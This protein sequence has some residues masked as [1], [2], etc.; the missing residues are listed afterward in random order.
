LQNRWNDQE[1]KAAGSELALRCYTSQLLGRDPALVLHG[2]GNTSV[3]LAERNVLGEVED[4]L[5]VKGSGWDLA[6]IK[7]PGFAPVK[8]AHLTRLAQLPALSD[9]AMVNE[10]ATHVTRAS[11]PA[12]SVEAI[13]H[14]ILPY[15]FVDHTH[16]DSVLAITNTR[17]G[18]ARI[19]EAYGTRSSSSR[20]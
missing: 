20:T 16:A 8:L 1:A 19:R 11:A 7:E 3:K 10:L 5:Y 18:D 9:V 15:K 2:G 6:T 17:D 4:I 13:L 12:P 14:A